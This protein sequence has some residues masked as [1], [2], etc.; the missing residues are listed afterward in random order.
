MNTPMDSMP[1]ILDTNKGLKTMVQICKYHYGVYMWYLVECPL[2]V[3]KEGNAVSLS[4]TD[5]YSSKTMREH[6]QNSFSFLR[7]PTCHWTGSVVRTTGIGFNSILQEKS[8]FSH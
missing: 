6:F 8:M 4:Y 1:A 5:S 2:C 3:S 7:F